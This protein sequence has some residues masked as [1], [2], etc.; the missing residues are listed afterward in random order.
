MAIQGMDAATPLSG[1][2]D[3]R[4]KG[5][6]FDLAAD[7]TALSWA[8]AVVGES[9]VA[10]LSLLDD[11]LAGEASLRQMAREMGDP[12]QLLQ[13]AESRDPIIEALSIEK[14]KEL[15]L[16]FGVAPD[17]VVSLGRRLSAVLALADDLR[18]LYSFFGLGREPEALTRHTP[19]LSTVEAGYP[20]FD[21]QR[22]AAL[23]AERMLE[24]QPRRALLH[25]P[26]GAGKTRTAL[27]LV[28]DHLRRFGPTL[29]IWLANSPELL[30]QAAEEFDTAWRSLGDRPVSLAR[31]WGAS[32]PDLTDLRDGFLVAGFQ[33]V[34]AGYRRDSN[35]LMVLGD[36]TTLTVVDEAHQAIAPTY[37]TVIDALAHKNP[38]GRL[39]GLSATPGRSWD[40][41]EADAE[42]SAFF[43]GRKVGLEIEGYPDPVAYLMDNGY[44]AR[45]V[46]K[47]LNAEAGPSLG[48]YDRE[49][50]AEALDVPE[51]LLDL[52]AED[53]QRN[54]KIVSAVED[55]ATRH[56]RIV[57]FAATVRHA[58]LI[59]AVLTARG[60]EA[61]VVT[62]AM[63]RRARERAI[64]RYKGA[65]S[66]T[67]VMCNFGVLTTGFDAPQTS[68]ALIARPTR[69]LVL[70]SQMVGRATRGRRAGGGDE[71]EIITVVDPDLP[72]FGD[73]ADAFKNW[74]DVWND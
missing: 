50:L 53:E 11:A 19:V 10:L 25:M 42:L 16:G 59:R 3:Y 52:L 48:A 73:V 2:S 74:E 51:D 21:H 5:Y 27:H 47:T 55:L 63:D 60:H 40:D 13:V 61:L 12:V 64:R 30:D 71:A 68:A 57:V 41:V 34:H 23:R 17:P 31:Y 70:Y 26:T 72:G 66:E 43:G 20:L 65:S 8:R 4:G 49:S 33:K 54:L 37:R 38:K 67:I 36:R 15:A 35:L 29:V 62:G 58:H 28:C 6:P 1:P 39:L 45:P 18:P 32:A 9:V 24:E 56:K 69:S 7:R 44:L 46:F 22:R 14:L